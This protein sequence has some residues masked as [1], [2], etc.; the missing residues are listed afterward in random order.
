MA[1]MSL[2]CLEACCSVDSFLLLRSAF[3]CSHGNTGGDEGSIVKSANMKTESA[4]C[5]YV[6]YLGGSDQLG[7]TSSDLMRTD[8]ELLVF[9]PASYHLVS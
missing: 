8:D 4:V 3:T 2:T 9:T 7:G 6:L 1:A 5:V